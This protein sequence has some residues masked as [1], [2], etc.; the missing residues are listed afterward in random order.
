M[1]RGLVWL[2]QHVCD[3]L[4]GIINLLQLV[5]TRQEHYLSH[6]A[7]ITKNN[8]NNKTGL[9]QSLLQY[10]FLIYGIKTSFGFIC[11]KYCN[12]YFPNNAQQS[13]SELW[14]TE[15]LRPLLNFKLVQS[16]VYCNLYW[17]IY[18]FIQIITFRIKQIDYD[19]ERNM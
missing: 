5:K 8:N 18:V 3:T 2:H 1:R 19:Y 16:L 4:W 17:A 10:F 14:H 9:T 6:E 15:I 7:M 13:R 12:V 11:T